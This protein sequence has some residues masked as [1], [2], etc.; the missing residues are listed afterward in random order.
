MFL[1]QGE[2]PPVARGRQVLSQERGSQS[3]AKAKPP[4][5]GP[6]PLQT[7]QTCRQLL[8]SEAAISDQAVKGTEIPA[9]VYNW[10]SCQALSRA[11]ERLLFAAWG[12]TLFLLP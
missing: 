5:S 10:T 1:E 8:P 4:T 7:F 12:P 11:S 9:K 6:L 3:A 2:G